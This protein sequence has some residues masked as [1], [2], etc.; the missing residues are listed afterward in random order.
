MVGYI[1]G[2]YSPCFKTVSTTLFH[3]TASTYIQIFQVTSEW[4]LC[5]TFWSRWTYQI[6]H[7]RSSLLHGCSVKEHNHAARV[8]STS[9][10]QHTQLDPRVKGS[11]SI[12][13]KS[14]R[15]SMASMRFTRKRPCRL[16]LVS[17]YSIIV[18]L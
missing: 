13:S 5:L 4:S 11:P 2:T 12:L 14:T 6:Y 10:Q 16:N 8:C 15:L 7:F 17:K 18:S 3:T 1:P 9:S